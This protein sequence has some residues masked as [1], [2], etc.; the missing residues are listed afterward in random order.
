MNPEPNNRINTT[1]PLLVDQQRQP[2]PPPPA[3]TPLSVALNILCTMIGGGIL[4]IPLAFSRAS[5][6]Y[7]LASVAL[8]CVLS[9]TSVWY[10]IT[11]CD[12][13]NIF[14]FRQLIVHAFPNT[15][16]SLV[17]VGLETI[18]FLT[19]T[20]ALIIYCRVISDALPPVVT[21][22]VGR[23]E[24][25]SNRTFWIAICAVVFSA[26]STLRTLHELRV[27]SFFGFS[28]I[29]FVCVVVVIHFGEDGAA[30]ASEITVASLRPDILPGFSTIIGAYL[31]HMNVPPL[32]SEL[33]HR[34][35]RKMMVGTNAACLMALA[36][37]SSVGLMGY[38]TFGDA[39]IRSSHCGGNVLN[40]YS[41]H[42]VMANTGRSV[43]VLHLMCVFPI[44]VVVAR[45]SLFIIV[46]G[47]TEEVQFKKRF[48]FGLLTVMLVVVSANFV[49]GIGYISSLTGALFGTTV[50][51]TVPSLLWLRLV[52]KDRKNSDWT[53][54]AAIVVFL[55]GLL[56]TVSSV[57]VTISDLSTS[58]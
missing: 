4:S 15:S 33:S 56:E 24:L 31:F 7:G 5:I 32:Y 39:S 25:W 58:S 36:L 51:V 12:A 46:T 20:S 2:P 43:L 9:I 42:D 40:N 53:K 17:G 28:A 38:I 44:Y 11:A 34:T 29:L 3:A 30:P 1:D 57:M 23:N 52:G 22:I 6:V 45:R 37:Y 26:M 50:G 21:S 55:F 41:D 27:V 10:I 13:H 48:G 47:E 35:V 49:P 54:V 14:S 8:S 18:I 19:T 16:P